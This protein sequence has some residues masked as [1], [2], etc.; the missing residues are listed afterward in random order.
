MSERFIPIAAPVLAGTPAPPA[1]NLQTL[2][3]PLPTLFTTSAASAPVPL[4]GTTPAPAAAPL[5]SNP[6]EILAV[7]GVQTR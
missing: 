7:G 6:K 5:R 3:Q 1:P 2:L 4:I